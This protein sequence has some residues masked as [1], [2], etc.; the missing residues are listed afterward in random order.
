MGRL[1]D[2]DELKAVID[3][4]DYSEEGY[5]ERIDFEFLYEVI[6]K[7]PTA[8]NL[9]T[10]VQQLEEELILADSEKKRCSEKN[11]LQFD[12]TKG[13]ANGIANAIEI[14]RNG[15]VK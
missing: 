10:V 9:E 8:Y 11:P 1:I 12:V 5:A 6:D 15:G 14:I 13:Y 2:A 4:Y 3:G 7:Q